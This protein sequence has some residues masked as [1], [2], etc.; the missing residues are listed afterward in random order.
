M[1]IH[2]C[3]LC[4]VRF[5]SIQ[6]PQKKLWVEKRADYLQKFYLLLLLYVYHLIASKV[7]SHNYLILK[8]N[9]WIWHCFHF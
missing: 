7:L 5:F 6:S 2:I 4:E 3:N 9:L 1:Y 8:A